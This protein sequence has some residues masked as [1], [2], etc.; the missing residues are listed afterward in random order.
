MVSHP[1]LTISASVRVFL[2]FSSEPD[3]P[4]EVGRARANG[5]TS[6]KRG[7]GANKL[8]NTCIQL[9]EKVV[10]TSLAPYLVELPRHPC[11]NLRS[12][13]SFLRALVGPVDG[14]PQRDAT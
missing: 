11:W 4:R 13:S 12:R 1:S 14:A 3:L 5:F 10:P 7:Y 8:C 2:V 6:P 9:V